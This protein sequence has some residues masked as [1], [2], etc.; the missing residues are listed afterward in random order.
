MLCVRSAE[1]G[2]TLC[3]GV[4]RVTLGSA[5]NVS[6]NSISKVIKYYSF[7]ILISLLQ[8]YCCSDEVLHFVTLIFKYPLSPRMSKN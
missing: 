3:T 5:W 6:E 4:M 2:K 7:V 1:R 8:I